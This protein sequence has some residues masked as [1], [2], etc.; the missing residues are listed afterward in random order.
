[1]T[2]TC[3][4]ERRARYF[5]GD[6]GFACVRDLQ[7]HL[8]AQGSNIGRN[9]LF[10]LIRIAKAAGE[11]S[12]DLGESGRVAINTDVLMKYANRFAAEAPKPA[13]EADEL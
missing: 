5:I 7:A 13:A 3:L 10:R 12:I 2:S 8:A 6:L 9:K 1:M 4:V 11:E